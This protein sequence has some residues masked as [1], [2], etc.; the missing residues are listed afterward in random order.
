M[1]AVYGDMCVP[2]PTVTRWA[3]MLS[4]GGQEARY[5]LR[6]NQVHKYGTEKLITDI[7]TAIKENR[8][9]NIRDVANEFNVLTSTTL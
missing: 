8:R 4:G 1:L 2:K 7:D 9:R 3:R 5:L 6:P